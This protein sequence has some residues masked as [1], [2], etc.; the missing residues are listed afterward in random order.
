MLVVLGDL[1]FL[2]WVL[3][4]IFLVVYWFG[5]FGDLNVRHVRHE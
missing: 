2:I 4:R 3:V 1:A 5:Y